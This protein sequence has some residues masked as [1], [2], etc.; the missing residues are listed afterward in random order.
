[1][2]KTE[3][4]KKLGFTAL[5]IICGALEVFSQDGPFV[6]RDV[7]LRVQGRTRSFVLMQKL[8]A[9][10]TMIGKTFDNLASFEAFIEHQRQL[11]CNYRVIASALSS[12]GL[13]PGASGGSD[14]HVRFDVVDTWNLALLPKP[15]P[16]STPW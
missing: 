1:M 11:I 2:K 10:G 3:P 15:S 6:I 14:A 13:S 7:D 8:L 12:Y 4:S 16:S 5:M 9:D